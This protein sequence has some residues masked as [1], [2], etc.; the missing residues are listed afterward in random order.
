MTGTR[1]FSQAISEG[2]GISIVVPVGDPGTARDAEEQ[3]AEALALHAAVES[4]PEATSLPLLWRP[5]GAHDQARAADADACVLAFAELADENGELEQEY[6]TALELGL[7]CAVE[8]RDESELGAALERVDPEIFLLAAGEGG[9]EGPLERALDLLQDVPAGKLAIAELPVSSRD[10][11]A[12]RE[13][14]GM[15][16]VIVPGGNVA[17]LVGGNHFDV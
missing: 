13:R 5:H 4:L 2:D 15:D 12:E 1:R 10:V 8:V 14:A 11:V 3:G 17:E 7:E 16:A 9:D 6:R